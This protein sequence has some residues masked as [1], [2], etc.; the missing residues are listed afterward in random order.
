LE[1]DDQIAFMKL[2]GA[3]KETLKLQIELDNLYQDIESD[4]VT[5]STEAN[6]QTL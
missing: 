4:L 2:V 5:F 3:I 1:S 6:Q